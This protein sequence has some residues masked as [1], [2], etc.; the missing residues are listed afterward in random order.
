MAWWFPGCPQVQGKGTGDQAVGD[1]G[2]QGVQ[3]Q[4]V[5]EPPRKRENSVKWVDRDKTKRLE[6]HLG[7]TDL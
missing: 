3:S 1:R 6:P 5:G 2:R 7:S 4:M